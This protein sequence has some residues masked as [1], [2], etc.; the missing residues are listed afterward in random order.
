MQQSTKAF[1]W[2]REIKMAVDAEYK[3]RPDW[4]WGAFEGFSKFR[5]GTN[6]GVFP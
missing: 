1:V 6:P 4:D 2:G 5:K 3:G